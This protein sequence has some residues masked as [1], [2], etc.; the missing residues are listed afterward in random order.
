M[1]LALT[2]PLVGALGIALAGRIGAET[3]TG[4]DQ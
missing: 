4:L 3:L 1:L 2:L